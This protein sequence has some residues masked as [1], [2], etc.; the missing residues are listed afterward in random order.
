MVMVR[1]EPFRDLL[2]TQRQLNRLFSETFPLGF[3]GFPGSLKGEEPNGRTWA[4]AVDIFE[5]DQNMVLKVELAGVDPK[6]VEVRVENNT[7]YLKGQRKTE[8]EVEEGK[9]HH[10]ERFF[11]SFARSFALPSSIDGEKVTAEY[12]DGILTLTLPKKEEAKPKAIKIAVS[13]G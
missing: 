4:P 8:K 2:V 13:R 9:Y 3:E 11:G 6:D 5:T 12:R 1:W 7:L 10:T